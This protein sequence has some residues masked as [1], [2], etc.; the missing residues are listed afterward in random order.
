MMVPDWDVQTKKARRL[1]AEP[2]LPIPDDCDNMQSTSRQQLRGR[3]IRQAAP[4]P[5][6]QQNRV[7]LVERSRTR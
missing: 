6:A 2:L 5:T 3:K 1:S 4:I 7:V